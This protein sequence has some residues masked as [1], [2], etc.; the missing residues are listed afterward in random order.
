MPIRRP[1]G[2]GTLA[3][4]SIRLLVNHFPIR[5]NSEAAIF[6]Y[7]VDIEH[8]TSH[9]SPHGKKRVLK[10]E[11]RLI[12]D[13]WFSDNQLQILQ[14]TCD[15]VKNIFSVVPL[16]TGEFEVDLSDGEDSKSRSYKFTLKFVNELKFSKLKEYLNENLSYNPRDILQV[17]DLVMKDNPSRLRISV[18]RGFYSHE[19]RAGDDLHFGVAAHRGFKQSVK[20]T[21][22]SLALCLDHSVLAFH[23]PLPII[24][25]LKEHVIGFKEVNDVKRLREEVIHVLKGLKVRVTHR[26]T[27]HVYTIAGLS[28]KNASEISFPLVGPEGKPTKQIRL[29]DY[30]KD[31]WRTDI[32]FKDIPCLNLSKNNRPN[33]VPL[34]FCVLVEGQRYPNECLGGQAGSNLR[35]KSLLRPEERMNAIHEM[36]QANDG[37]CGEVMQNFGMAVDVNMTSVVSRVIDAPDLKLGN[38]QVVKVDKEKC[39]WNL[40]GKSLV[41]ARPVKRWALIDFSNG[42]LHA[43]AFIKNL[44]LRSRK[45]GMFMEDPLVFRVTGMHEFL[46]VRR[47]DK[48]LTSLKE[49]SSGKNDGKLQIIICVMKEEHR[50]Y[51]YLKWVS[52]IQIG[53]VTQCCLMVHANKGQDQYLAN[54][55]LKINAK[56][57]GSNF[58]L[59]ERLPNFKDEDHVMFIGADVNHP[60]QGNSSCPSIVAVVGSIN[61]PAANRYAARVCPQEHRKEKIVNFGT[62]CLDLVKT[63]ARLNRVWPNKIVIFRDGVSDGQ[64]GMVLDEELHDLEKAIYDGGHYKPKITVVVAQKRHQTRLFLENQQDGGASG[65]VPPGTVVDTTI[66]HPFEFDFYLCSHYGGIGTSRPTH[67]YVLRDENS[68]TS[69]GI[70]KLIYHM[71][72]T[73]AR[74]TKP[75]SLVPPVYYAD[76]VAFRGRMYQ[77][78]K[79]E[80]QPDGS[81]NQRFYDIHPD[82]QDV[83]FFV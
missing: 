41:E 27:Q 10:S 50:G 47:L 71:C 43:G 69:D 62:I 73:Y 2:G 20:L 14:T 3:V 78:V 15:G 23:K 16:P 60:G 44:K 53:V 29:V 12:I 72:F 26:D 11:L 75:V 19:F 51:E 77:E 6:H 1:D 28:E 25:F 56:L 21:A 30:F 5:F 80:L 38:S 82:L 8:V 63:Y 70:Q 49:E 34:E 54:L 52:E 55:C 83:M 13:Q 4:R 7:N 79:M 61:W 66:V 58:E 37:P 46:H 18:G 64:F 65:N 17:M 40:V 68:F 35:R 81:F 31:K 45:L 48:L 9:E 76:V 33:D 67:Y 24:E 57:G 39:Q 59:I 22:Q 74:C 42:G 36:V 32:L